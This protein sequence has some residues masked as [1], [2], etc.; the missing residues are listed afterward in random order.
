M[1]AYY[2]LHLQTF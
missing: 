2:N 1:S